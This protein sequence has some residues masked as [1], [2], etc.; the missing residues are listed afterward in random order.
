MRGPSN[1]NSG[2]EI[3]R[4]VICWLAYKVSILEDLLWDLPDYAVTLLDLRATLSKILIFNFHLEIDFTD[5]SSMNFHQSWQVGN[6][7]EI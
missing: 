4:D 2:G 7:Y 5:N 1:E 3:A 6:K